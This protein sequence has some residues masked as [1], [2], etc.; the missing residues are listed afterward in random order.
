M[1]RSARAWC[2]VVAALWACGG[3]DAQRR[4]VDAYVKAYYARTQA[5][6]SDGERLAGLLFD[7]V[8][9]K[10]ADGAEVRRAHT[11]FRARCAQALAEV[12]ADAGRL[13]LPAFA[14]WHAAATRY[15]AFECETFEDF[16]RLIVVAEATARP[17]A[18][19]G[20]QI[21]ALA[22]AADALESAEKA[23]IEAA[24]KRLYAFLSDPR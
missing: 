5:L 13:T 10:A 24:T 1:A 6:T 8:E 16:P 22:T 19:R 23:R 18:E 4:E 21:M 12:K 17:A 11:T 7:V 2:W 14:E 3:E 20:R 9:G 15:L